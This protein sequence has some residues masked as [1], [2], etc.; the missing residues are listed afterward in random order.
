MLSLSKAPKMSSDE[1][2][3]AFLDKANKDPNEGHDKSRAQAGS[4]GKDEFKA[5]D[6]GVTVPKVLLNA[7]RNKFYA[8]D[9]DEPFKAVALKWDEDGKGLP[10]EGASNQLYS[11]IR[12]TVAMSNSPRRH[13]RI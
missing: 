3:L 6:E 12:Y 4:T 11:D 9:A 10:D 8:S 5:T 13:I 2:Y 7:V 1:D